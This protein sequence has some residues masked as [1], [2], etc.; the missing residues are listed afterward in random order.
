MNLQEWFDRSRG[1]TSIATKDV[2]IDDS[3]SFGETETSAERYPVEAIDSISDEEIEEDARII[4]GLHM[5]F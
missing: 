2:N 4:V 1:K 3:I 5:K